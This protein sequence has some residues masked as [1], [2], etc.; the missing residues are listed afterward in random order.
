MNDQVRGH[1]NP[2]MSFDLMGFA[3]WILRLKELSL[4]NSDTP[5]MEWEIK[6]Q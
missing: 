5:T 2:S 1:S 4:Q 3:D 6:E